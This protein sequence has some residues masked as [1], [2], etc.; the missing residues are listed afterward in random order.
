[1]FIP[2]NQKEDCFKQTHPL[3]KVSINPAKI[4][5]KDIFPMK[6]TQISFVNEVLIK[7]QMVFSHFM[8]F[9]FLQNQLLLYT[10][11][12]VNRSLSICSTIIPKLLYS[13]VFV[14]FETQGNILP[15]VTDGFSI[16]CCYSRIFKSP[17]MHLLKHDTAVIMQNMIY[18]FTV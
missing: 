3:L 13:N 15:T 2:I 6:L 10:F 1:M 14:P 12:N 7:F 5:D 8:L 11:I 17:K 18:M 16:F 9:N 4:L